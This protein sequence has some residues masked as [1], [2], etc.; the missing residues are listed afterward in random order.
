MSKSTKNS[1]QSGGYIAAQLGLKVHPSYN[2]A[3]KS[4]LN[5]LFSDAIHETATSFAMFDHPSWQSFFKQLS[6][7]WHT[8]SPTLISTDLLNEKYTE[9]QI[10]M[11]CELADAPAVIIGMDGATNVLSRSMSNI[12]AHDPRPWF[13]EYLPADLKKESE[14]ELATKVVSSLDRLHSFVDK[15][16]AVA[17]V[18]DSCN[19][20]RALRRNLL[21]NNHFTWVYGCGAHPLNN[22]CQDLLKLPGLNECLKD[23]VFICKTIKNQGLLF[24]IYASVCKELLGK[25]YSMVLYSASR[26]SSVNYMFCRLKCI[27]RVLMSMPLIIENEKPERGIDPSFR[28]SKAFAA[29]V[30]NSEFWQRV[31]QCVALFDPICKCIGVLESDSSTMATTYACFVF[32][33]V[34][35]STVAPLDEC[36]PMLARLQY[37]WNRIYSPVHA[38]AFFC[39]PFY[40]NFRRNVTTNLGDVAIELDNGDLKGQCREALKQLTRLS[41]SSPNST[42]AFEDLLSE[43]LQFCI[44]EDK[45]IND[46]QS[47]LE[48]HPRLIWGQVSGTYPLLSSALIKVFTAPGSTSGVER[49]HKIGKRVHN[50]TRSRSGNGKVERQVAVGHNCAIAKRSLSSKRQGFEKVIASCCSDDQAQ[51]TE[52]STNDLVMAESDLCRRGNDEH[53]PNIDAVTLLLDEYELAEQEDLHRLLPLD[54]TPD[55]IMDSILF[56]GRHYDSGNE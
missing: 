17:F 46:V 21:D 27:K 40:F 26:W 48:F 38:L 56:E 50:A 18:S 5:R 39:D 25:C 3:E 7:S 16:V 53:D 47:I 30:V 13:V 33:Y 1:L 9:V 14:S 31:N 24:K 20:M 35:I 19:A 8:P 29:V 28:L 36:E 45:F 6:P 49:Q 55:D 43:F 23:A 32:I 15:K 41:E 52:S 34:H 10:K 2:A 51:V 22:F 44:V 4:Q 54:G 11:A 42:A 37:R 12:I